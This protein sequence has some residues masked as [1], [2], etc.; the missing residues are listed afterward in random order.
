MALLAFALLVV[1]DVRSSFGEGAVVLIYHKFGDSRTPSTNVPLCNF[2]KQMLY[3]KT[4]GY[5][6]IP[7]KLLVD[8]LRLKKPLFPKS[9]VITIDDGYKTVFTN[10]FPILKKFG[11]TFTVFLPTEAIE[12]HYS[13]YLSWAQIE[14]MKK[15]GADFQDHTYSHSP[16]GIKPKSMDESDYRAWIRRDLKKSIEIFEKRLGYVPYALAFPYGYYNEIL[17]DEAKKLGYKALL[18][19]DPGVVSEHTSLY[20]IPREPILGK[21]WSTMEHFKKVLKRVDLPILSHKPSIGFLKENPP[22]E[23]SAIL[24]YPKLYLPS[25]FKIYITEIGW[26]RANFDPKLSEVFING[27]PKLRRKINR[28]A[29]KGVEKN[30]KREAIRFWMVI[31]P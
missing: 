3:L 28:I 14:K 12:K 8:S 1:L 4:C 9:V 24:A 30:G 16:F 5:H 19:Q 2:K 22:R 18:T 15:Y 26:R 20:L 6:V 21:E 29:I 13:D 11:Y 17:I 27:V 10:A 25:K 31:L 23:I 7:L